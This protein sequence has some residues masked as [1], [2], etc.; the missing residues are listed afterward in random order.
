MEVSKQ[1]INSPSSLFYDFNVPKEVKYKDE[2]GKVHV[3]NEEVSSIYSQ[4][5]KKRSFGTQNICPLESSSNEENGKVEYKIKDRNFS[6]MTDANL[7][8]NLPGLEVDDMYKDT[9]RICYPNNLAH[10]IVK[11]SSLIINKGNAP[12]QSW[13]T[14]SLDNYV[15]NYMKCEAKEDYK[16]LIGNIPELTN[17]STKLPKMEL[18]IP[19]LFSFFVVKEKDNRPR[20]ALP[21][22]YDKD[23]IFFKYHFNLVLSKLIK[24]EARRVIKKGSKNGIDKN[25]KKG[26]KKNI[27]SGSVSK[28]KRSDDSDSSDESTQI[29]NIVNNDDD[30]EVQ[31]TEWTKVDVRMDI[32]KKVKLNLNMP[33]LFGMFDLVSPEEVNFYK[34]T[35]DAPYDILVKDFLVFKAEND[36]KLAYSE[37]GKNIIPVAIPFSS[38]FGCKAIHWLAKNKESEKYNQP[39]NYTVNPDDS[40]GWSPL[41]DFTLAYANNTIKINEVNS[42]TIS[43]MHNKYFPGRPS[44]SGYCRISVCKNP[45]NIGSDFTTDISKGARATIKI[46]DQS[47]YNFNNDDDADPDDKLNKMLSKKKKMKGPDI[48]FTAYIIVAVEKKLSFA[49]GREMVIHPVEKK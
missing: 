30:T 46:I 45:A 48:S 18:V 37:D 14:V 49:T 25:G 20:G 44:V 4:S 16:R 26:V 31:Y 43:L 29:G 32:L 40:N 9:V 38:P 11:E 5:N 27:N 23:K 15:E 42:Q 34:D 10:S 41:G 7:V 36:I 19:Q 6:F 22:F 39:S 1:E 24:M 47:P 8:I 28:S 3:K 2:S 17:W 21:L 13:S 33:Q 12:I 35:H